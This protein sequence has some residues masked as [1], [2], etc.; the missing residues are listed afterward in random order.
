MLVQWARH[1]QNIANLTN[2]LSHRSFDGDLTELGRVQAHELGLWLSARGRPRPGLLAC[3][4]LRRARQTAEI[5]G[6]SLGLGIGLELDALREVDVGCLDGSN[7]EDAWQTYHRVLSGWRA[8]DRSLRFPGGENCFELCDR[9]RLA[10]GV[11]VSN[12]MEGP[13]LIIG[14]G[15]NLRA[16]LPWLTG[17]PDP[18]RDLATGDLALLDVTSDGGDTIRVKLE[19]W[20][21]ATPGVV[22]T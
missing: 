20:G 11:V 16:S 14:H 4:P 2:T 18:G 8:G 1:G 10:M 22:K 17:S 3:S 19:S 12:S 9:V 13:A 7:D 15:A 5:V 6:R 21:E